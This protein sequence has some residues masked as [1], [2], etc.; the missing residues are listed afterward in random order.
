M[1]ATS[2]WRREQFCFAGTEM[3]KTKNE[4]LVWQYLH[5][6][7]ILSWQKNG[8]KCL[9]PALD[10]TS[11][12]SANKS[13]IIELGHLVLHDGAGVAQLSA[14]VLIIARPD[15][16]QRAVG[17]LAQGDHFEGHRKCLVGAPV[18]G[19]RRADDGGRAGAHQLARVL[20]HHLIEEALAGEEKLRWA[21]HLLAWR[22][23]S[24]AELRKPLA[25]HWSTA[26]E[27][28]SPSPPPLIPSP[29]PLSL[30]QLSQLWLIK[31]VN[32]AQSRRMGWVVVL[33]KVKQQSCL[34]LVTTKRFTVFTGKNISC[35]VGVMRSLVLSD[36]INSF[37]GS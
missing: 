33:F 23:H 15:G 24:S 29:S 14:P 32:G 31:K 5:Q 9:S 6:W 3:R 13:Q 28:L 7:K 18:G 30:S 10:L 35:W 21:A 37:R 26:E 27:Q 36:K 8:E 34:K 2:K 19:Q 25:D 4:I 20:V 16:D 17:D 11:S 1:E 12:T 22:G